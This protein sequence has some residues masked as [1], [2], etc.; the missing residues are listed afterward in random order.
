MD[1][2][3]GEIMGEQTQFAKRKQFNE[4]FLNALK[5]N[6]P[7]VSN[8]AEKQTDALFH[9]LDV[10]KTTLDVASIVAFTD[11]R[12]IIQHANDNFCKISGYQREELLGQD[13]RLVNSK[14]HSREFFK[15]MWKTISSGRVWRGEIRNLTKAGSPYWVDTT[16][17]PFFNESHRPNQYV[18]IR[19][20]IT[21]RKQIQQE[22]EEQRA[23][24]SFAERM[25]SLGELTAGIGHE[26]ANPI[27]AIQG[28]AELLNL[29]A[30]NNSGPF[31]EQAQKTV[32]SI[33]TMT[34]RMQSILKSMRS[35]ARGDSS[36]P[37]FPIPIYQ[38]VRNTI[39]FGSEKFRKRAVSVEVVPCDD[40]LMVSCR[41]TEVM[42]ILINL[43]NNA[44]DAVT[45]SSEKWI[46]VEVQDDEEHVSLMV[47]DSGT[48]IP[49]E[50]R[51]KLF[52]AFFTTKSVG[53]GTGLGLNISKKLAQQQGGDLYIDDNCSHT[54]F[55][56]R[57][58][59]RARSAH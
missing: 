40:N 21:E 1:Y 58:P 33:L 49:A 56:L 38:L 14:H 20:D 48:G 31:A 35:L 34:G 57:L 7:S 9:E 46:H 52:T 42:Q 17:V 53:K 13:H 29:L 59:K 10:L 55:V 51:P 6:C 47:T 3:K 45:D 22:L 25:A 24:V 19:N 36:D 16:I 37:Y 5:P 44:C 39:D 43:L 26:L 12:G 27:A 15:E 41:E 23:R 32:E 54:R 28:R 4:L 11:G 2:R 18:A 30:E 50:V 8:P